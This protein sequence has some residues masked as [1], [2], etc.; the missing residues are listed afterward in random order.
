[1]TT[2]MSRKYTPEML[3]AEITRPKKKGGRPKKYQS[4]EER[5]K[6]ITEASKRRY[7]R[8]KYA[9]E[10]KEIPEE[11]ALRERSYATDEERRIAQAQRVARYRMYHLEE[12]RLSAMAR[13]HQRQR[14]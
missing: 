13:K 2:M 3:E 5:K 6:A 7:W 12:T 4:E 1:M 11:Y 9:E 14:T 8:K 10:C